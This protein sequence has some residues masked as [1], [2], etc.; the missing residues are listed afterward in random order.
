V[1]G[2]WARL[3]VTPLQGFVIADMHGPRRV[4]PRGLHGW[5]L[6]SESWGRRCTF[7]DKDNASVMHT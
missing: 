7:S 1:T 2:S 3:L 6:S 4:A 5:A